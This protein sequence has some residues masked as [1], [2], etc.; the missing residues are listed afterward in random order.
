MTRGA[1]GNVLSTV[2]GEL[3]LPTAAKGLQAAVPRISLQ[4]V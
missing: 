2:P 3:A 1:R 4:K